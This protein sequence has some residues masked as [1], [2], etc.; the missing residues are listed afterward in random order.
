MEK[1]G[2]QIGEKRVVK[3]KVARTGRTGFHSF[4]NDRP[5][6]KTNICIVV[7]SLTYMGMAKARKLMALKW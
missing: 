7:N 5:A 3:K 2:E 4:L 1:S 6:Y